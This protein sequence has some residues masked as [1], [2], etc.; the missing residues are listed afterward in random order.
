MIPF[1][2]ETEIKQ[3][4]VGIRKMVNEAIN[5]A[6][7]YAL[8]FE[9]YKHLWCEKYSEVLN[10]HLKKLAATM[11]QQQ[12]NQVNQHKRAFAINNEY[13]VMEIFKREVSK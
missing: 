10:Q 4:N 5:A 2:D 3:L 11:I 7:N 1:L 8:Q 6:K 9:T 13:S 12:T